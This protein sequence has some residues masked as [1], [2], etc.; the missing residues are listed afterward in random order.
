MIDRA[1]RILQMGKRDDAASDSLPIVSP[2]RSGQT[3]A[4]DSCQLPKPGIGI[5]IVQRRG[6]HVVNGGAEIRK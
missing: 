6:R 5:G 4:V 2:C 3:R 1:T